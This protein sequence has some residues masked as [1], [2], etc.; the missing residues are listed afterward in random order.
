M[1]AEVYHKPTVLR[2]IEPRNGCAEY[3]RIAEYESRLL[4]WYERASKDDLAA[5]MSWYEDAQ[6]FCR[7]LAAGTR[8]SVAQ[9]AACLAV[10]SAQTAWRANK[11]NLRAVV[12]WHAAGE[13]PL[14]YVPGYFISGAQLRKCAAILDGKHGATVE[15]LRGHICGRGYY[16]TQNFFLNLVGQYDR[17]CMDTWMARACLGTGRRDGTQAPHGRRYQAMEQAAIYAAHR[18]GIP[19]AVFQAV[20]WTA[21]RGGAE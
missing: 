10:L 6:E 13:M 8:Y 16:K 12:Q 17:V 5:G 20:V 14:G 18:A 2:V 3:E 7:D 11:S 9:V 21:I 1:V 19:A 15:T 4:S